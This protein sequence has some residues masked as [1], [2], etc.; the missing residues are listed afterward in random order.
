MKRVLI[1]TDIQNDFLPGGALA[2]PEGDAILPFVT[3]LMRTGQH[4]DLIVVTQDWHPKGH[5]S[6]ASSHP[7][8][9]P[10]QLG[11]LS[12]LPQMLWPDHCVEET[13]GARLAAEIEE[14]LAEIEVNGSHLLF[15]KKGRDPEVDSYSAFFDNARRQDTGLES[16]LRE[17]GI[18]EV[19]VVGLTLDYCVKATALDAASLG[20][21]TRVLLQGTRTVDPSS[22]V[23]VL[24]ELSAAGVSCI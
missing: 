5:G 12:G 18:K 11:E 4:Y 6:F 13:S 9:Q 3:N 23:Q 24:A 17:H 15:V 8:A 20:F 10:F 2:V 21:K 1:V 22:E 14:V 16:S 19:D 7:G